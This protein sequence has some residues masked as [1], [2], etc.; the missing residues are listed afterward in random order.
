MLSTLRIAIATLLLAGGA[1][2]LAAPPC[3]PA[4]LRLT[5][6]GADGELNG[7]SHAGVALSIRNVGPDCTLAAPPLVALRDA[8]GR[9]LRTRARAAPVA[10]ALLYLGGGHRAVMVL[11]WIAAPVFPNSRQLQAAEVRLRF[12]RVSLGAPL[13]ARLYGAA[14]KAVEFEQ[15]PLRVVEGMAADL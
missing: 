6:D 13:D 7:M 8:R 5:V 14:G 9:P 11:R 3:K 2:A 15:G 10:K 1:P 4:Q 12:G